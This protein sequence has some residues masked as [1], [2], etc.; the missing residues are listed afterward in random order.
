MTL[1]LNLSLGDFMVYPLDRKIQSLLIFNPQLD[2]DELLM[3]S[4]TVQQARESYVKG[5][6]KQISHNVNSMS[7]SYVHTVSA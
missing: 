2:I 4:E 3:V 7:I 1:E 5:C 6:P